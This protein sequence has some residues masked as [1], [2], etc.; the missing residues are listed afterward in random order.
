LRDDRCGV[1]GSAANAA[2]PRGALPMS[3]SREERARCKSALRHH[4]PSHAAHRE[5]TPFFRLL[6][7]EI[8]RRTETGSGVVRPDSAT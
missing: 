7:P 6:V 8:R 3:A 5:R 1:R 4:A 2:S